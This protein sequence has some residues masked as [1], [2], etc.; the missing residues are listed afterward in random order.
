ML[1]AG[2]LNIDT[3]SVRFARRRCAHK[4]FLSAVQ[5]Q[6]S[7]WSKLPRAQRDI[8]PQL[9]LPGS[10]W[11]QILA[12]SSTGFFSGLVL[13]PHGQ[14]RKATLPQC[15]LFAKWSSSLHQLRDASDYRAICSLLEQKLITIQSQD[16]AFQRSAAVVMTMG[17]V[18]CSAVLY[19]H[20]V[21]CPWRVGSFQSHLRHC[22]VQLFTS[23][24]RSLHPALRWITIAM[25]LCRL[26]RWSAF[27]SQWVSPICI[28]SHLPQVLACAREPLRAWWIIS[29]FLN[30]N[31]RSNTYSND[32]DTDSDSD[33]MSRSEACSGD[34]IDKRLHVGLVKYRGDL[35][36]TQ[37]NRRQLHLARLRIAIVS[38]CQSGNLLTP[39]VTRDAEYEGQ[40]ADVINFEL[41]SDWPQCI[42]PV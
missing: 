16:F 11:A 25:K 13:V 18:H 10:V 30:P 15:C 35:N 24:V 39:Q 28:G 9:A 21:S 19:E 20:T 38:A 34:D 6:H 31:L 4:A 33:L 26:R 12:F 37:L 29:R 27:L 17:L 8:H 7:A 36:R 3:F 32:V 1:P 40:G 41:T 5:K 42:A 23:L 2:A 22:K 14:L